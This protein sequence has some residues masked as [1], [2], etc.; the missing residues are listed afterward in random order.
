MWGFF[1][2][3]IMATSAADRLKAL[4]EK[5]SED[6]LSRVDAMLA[7]I[8]PPVVAPVAQK[9]VVLP[10]QT[11]QSGVEIFSTFGAGSIL[12]NGKEQL[13]PITVT[14]P[15]LLSSLR[16]QYNIDTPQSYLR[17]RKV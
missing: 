14:D 2:L 13:L 11:T 15:I 8:L 3:F 16:S 10:A 7:S 6:R 4:R 12:V 9:E 5:K 1:L 17:S